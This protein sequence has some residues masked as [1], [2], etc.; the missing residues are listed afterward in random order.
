MSLISR[1]AL[2]RLKAPQ[3]GL[4][5]PREGPRGATFFQTRGEAG[6]FGDLAEEELTACTLA[7]L[8]PA[9]GVD[10]VRGLLMLLLFDRFG[11]DG[12]LEVALEPLEEALGVDGTGGLLLCR[13]CPPTA[14]IE[15]FSLK[16]SAA[17]SPSVGP[18]LAEA[19]F[20]TD[21]RAIASSRSH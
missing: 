4:D 3:R 12:S 1:V 10:G 16:A 17:I 7:A 21:C 6:D 15:A 2:V 9:F 18:E 19:Q 11:D 20:M 13:V 8:E 14:A 5:F